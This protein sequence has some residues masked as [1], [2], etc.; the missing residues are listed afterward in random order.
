MRL[1]MI[2]MGLALLL[3]AAGAHAQMYKWVDAK[4]VA[5]YTDT[6]PP[7]KP[8]AELKGPAGGPG[9]AALPYELAAAARNAPVTLY[10]SSACSA[11][12]MGRALLQTRGIPFS[13]KTVTSSDDIARLKEAGSEGQLP[14]LLVGR[15]KLVGFEAGAWNSALSNA[16]YPAQ[17]MLP[18][19]YRNG[20]VSAAA[21]PRAPSPPA[22]G[23]EAEAAA[24]A[25]AEARP[26]KKAPD[27]PPGFQF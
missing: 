10:T 24:R 22:Q 23:R 19:N 16:S 13:E 9:E 6:P 5:H 17:R 27:A 18:A 25:R 15:S 4:G 20:Q 3:C 2:P 8:A 21:P 7:D 14:L 1:A 26:Q 11:C 12:D